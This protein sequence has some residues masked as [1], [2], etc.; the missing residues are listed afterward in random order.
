MFNQNLYK[1]KTKKEE[2]TQ[3]KLLKENKLNTLDSFFY[4]YWTETI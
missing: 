1:K 3:E 4:F 2:Y